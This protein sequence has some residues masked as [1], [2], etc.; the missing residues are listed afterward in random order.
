MPQIMHVAFLKKGCVPPAEQ[1]CSCTEMIDSNK[2]K[3]GEEKKDKWRESVSWHRGKLKRKEILLEMFLF[4]NCW[5]LMFDVYGGENG[6]E[7]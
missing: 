3:K 4:L 5:Q 6:L 1:S 7:P 2:T